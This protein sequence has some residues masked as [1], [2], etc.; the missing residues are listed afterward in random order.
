MK[1]KSKRVTTF[2]G[3]R[4]YR[5]DFIPQYFVVDEN[6]DRIIGMFQEERYAVEMAECE[7]NCTMWPITGIEEG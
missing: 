1:I 4:E 3:G 5:G 6:V 7:V 2:I